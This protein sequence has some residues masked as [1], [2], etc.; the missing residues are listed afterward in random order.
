MYFDTSIL[1]LRHTIFLSWLLLPVGDW[2]EQCGCVGAWTKHGV[3]RQ[4]RALRKVEIKERQ[5]KPGRIEVP[6]GKYAWTHVCLTMKVFYALLPSFKMTMETTITWPETYHL[7]TT[8]ALYL[9]VTRIV[10]NC[11]SLFNCDFSSMQSDVWNCAF[12]TSYMKNKLATK[13]YYV[14]TKIFSLSLPLAPEQKG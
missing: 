6:K 1:R 12:C 7:R 2:Y 8:V 13:I 9:G 10:F 3:C 11:L 14:E 5:F 4:R